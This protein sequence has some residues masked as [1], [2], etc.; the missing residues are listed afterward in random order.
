MQHRADGRP[1]SSVDRGAAGRGAAVPGALRLHRKHPPVGDGRTA[2]GSAD[3]AG[4]ADRRLA[5]RAPQAAVD[6]EIGPFSAVALTDFGADPT[7]HVPRQLRPEFA[8][9]ADLI[10]TAELEHRRI[11]LNDAPSVLRR[12]FSLREFARLASH[13]EPLD[14][15]QPF[16][17]E[18]LR[19]QVLRISAQRGLVPRAT[20]SEDI[21]DPVRASLSETRQRAREIADAV[22]AVVISLGLSYPA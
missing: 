16:D 7:G 9:A 4:V 1:M 15:A 13:V 3:A 19:A 21:A 8:L 11:V 2:T 18:E 14:P 17:V 12:I 20:S 5:A 22:D 6:Q 10:L